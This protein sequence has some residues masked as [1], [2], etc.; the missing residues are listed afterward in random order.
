MPGKIVSVA[1][2]ENEEVE[3]RQLLVVLEAMKME[4]RIEAPLGGRVREIRVSAGA[5]V[6]AGE[7]LLTID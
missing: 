4:H 5:L 3:E 2:R 6:A 1:V 7:R